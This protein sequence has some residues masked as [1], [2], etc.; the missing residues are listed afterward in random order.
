VPVEVQVVLHMLVK[1]TV[2]STPDELVGEQAVVIDVP[3]V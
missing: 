3:V 2:L 1:V